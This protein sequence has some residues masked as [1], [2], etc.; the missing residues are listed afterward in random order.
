M[1]VHVELST[2]SGCIVCLTQW[3]YLVKMFVVVLW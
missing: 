3:I 1:I 2:M